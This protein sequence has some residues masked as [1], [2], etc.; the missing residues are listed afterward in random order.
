ME[1]TK[2]ELDVPER[3]G[4]LKVLSGV[5]GNVADMRILHEAM[6]VLGIPE[7]EYKEFAIT[8]DK[9]TGMIEWTN[10]H[11][12]TIE[13]GPRAVVILQNAL[14]KLDDAG[15]LLPDFPL[16]LFDKFDVE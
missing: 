7:S 16:S 9:K 11:E 10:N 15:D 13:L 4:A 12:V 5:K 3:L 14:K 8:V 1:K 2:F 6:T